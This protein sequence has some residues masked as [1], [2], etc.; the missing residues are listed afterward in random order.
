MS[1]SSGFLR[2]QQPYMP[3]LCSVCHM[4]S[5]ETL[6]PVWLSNDLA[7]CAELVWWFSSNYLI[8][9]SNLVFFFLSLLRKYSFSYNLELFC[10]KV[11]FLFHVVPFCQHYMGVD[12]LLNATVN[13]QLFCGHLHDF[14][15]CFLQTHSLGCTHFCTMILNYFVRIVPILPLVSILKPINQICPNI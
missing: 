3:L 4:V 7:N 8:K 10:A 6:T 15:L 2:G 12:F 13:C 14:I 1:F 11:T 9:W 5:R